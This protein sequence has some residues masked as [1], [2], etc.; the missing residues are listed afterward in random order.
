MH[1]RHV[2]I[3]RVIFFCVLSLCLL[4]CSASFLTAASGNRGNS[5]APGSQ[6]VS[7]QQTYARYERIP[8]L[9]AEQKQ[10]GRRMIEGMHYNQQR[11]LRELCLLPGMNFAKAQKALQILKSES[12]SY[13]QVQ[14]FESL[15]QLPGMDANTALQYLPIIKEFHYQ[16]ARTLQSYLKIKGVTLSQAIVMASE[17]N[18][19]GH[20]NSRAAAAFFAIPG[21]DLAQAQK[22]LGYLVK[23]RNN[24]ARA[25]EAFFSIR[26]I[27]P[28]MA[29]D[30]MPLLA[31][32]QQENAWNARWLFEE[33]SLGAKEA[34]EWLVS[35]FAL[36]TNVQEQQY[37]RLSN[38]K[39]SLLL[40]AFYRG[41]EKTIWRINN[42]HA[43]TDDVGY[44]ISAA[45][46]GRYSMHQLRAKF[47]ELPDSVKYRF[48]DSFYA[49]GHGQ[50]ISLLRQATSAARVQVAR[51]LTP[52]NAYAIMSQ[53][54]E[55]YDSSFRDIMV[56]VLQARINALYRGDLLV[57][58]RAV[59]PEN[60]LASDFIVSCAQKGKLTTFFP[61]DSA[62][63]KEVLTMVATSAFRNE[64]SIL[65][66]SATLTP[67]LK[68]LEPS[69]RSYLIGLMINESA[70][71]KSSYA[72]LISVILQYYLQ[73][74]PEL[75]SPEDRTRAA[76][77]VER[78]GSINL[79]QYQST[80]FAEWK[81][82]GHIGTLSMFHPDDDGRDS[83]ISNGN[84][85]LK[86]GYRLVASP[87]YSVG[88]S[89]SLTTN[90]S[91]LFTSMRNRHFAVAFE[92]QVN[93]ITITHNQ[94]VYA[95]K[96]NQM[97]ILRNFILSGDEILAQRGHSYWRSEQIIDPLR[98][99]LDEKRISDSDLRSKQRFLSLGSCGGVKVYTTLTQLFAGSVD[100]L[101]TIGTGLALINDPYNKQL[102]E[103]VANNPSSIT[104]KNVAS[105]TAFIFQGNRGQDYLQP[106]SLTAILHKILE[107]NF[108]FGPRS[109]RNY[110]S[111]ED[112]E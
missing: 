45:E 110:S 65:L 34:W 84:L 28:A 73:T 46:L 15:C 85:L 68:V 6:Q 91:A 41:G 87:R 70:N 54:A 66:F 95:S 9:S 12:F 107:G 21:M 33:K 81:A 19:I 43:V 48:H 20:L 7:F 82:D 92:K 112:D 67:L 76:A 69:A 97:E 47:E 101:A 55:F 102:P 56:P 57:F 106:G 99:L 11:I 31:R 86:S 61:S 4:L 10:Y 17:F 39:K 89:A 50:A 2:F 77:A 52:A 104:W 26:G 13:H 96:E 93:G 3:S 88:N 83:F 59:D 62:K 30:A 27:S 29:L 108:R 74:Y 5:G 25:A 44:E 53:A 90:L 35:F 100:I 58:M 60:L 72:K 80:P 79:E 64:E 18:R 16:V 36:P 23:L 14:V 94:I 51:D 24:Q 40:M 22:G 103:I 32:L 38:K 1:N 63:Q 111:F 49:A 75:L 42:L 78:V 37:N 109:M 71:T 8:G 105:Q 98:Q